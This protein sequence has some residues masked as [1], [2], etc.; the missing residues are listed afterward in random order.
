MV[1]V[2]LHEMSCDKLMQLNLQ[3][4]L[5]AEYRISLK[6]SEKVDSRSR[7]FARAA[8][9]TRLRRLPMQRRITSKVLCFSTRTSS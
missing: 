1:N 2:H 5:P 4:K 8:I 6:A 9:V 7:K 3:A